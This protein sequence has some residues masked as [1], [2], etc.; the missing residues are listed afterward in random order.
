[1]YQHRS[2][3]QQNNRDKLPSIEDMLINLKVSKENDINILLLGETG[4]GKSTFINAFFNYIS[5]SSLWQAKNGYFQVVIPSQFTITDEDFQERV[6]KVGKDHNESIEIGASA[7]QSCRSYVYPV[8]GTDLKIRLIDTPG[9]GDTRGIEQ[10]NINFEN[11]LSFIGELKYLNAICILLK[12]NNS[13]LTVMFEF[14][15]KQL[16]SRLEKSASENLI[17]VFT[18]TRGTFYR[19]GETLPSLKKLLTTIKGVDIHCEKKNIFCTD[20]ESFR[21]L[22]ALKDN[23][24]FSSTDVN[25]FSQSWTQ[26]Y[27]ECLR[28]IK[29]IL[30]D[31]NNVGLIPHDVKNSISVNE[32]RRLIVQLSQPLAEI[33]ELIQ[34]N[35]RAAD[36]HREKLKHTDTSLVKLRSQ[37]YI[38]VI[39]LKVV[40]LNQPTT[41]CTSSKCSEIY[42]IGGKKK[43]HYHQTCHCP[44]YLNNVTKE[45]IGSPELI[46]CAA[47]NENGE[48]VQCSCRYQLHMHIYYLTE[49]YEAK[50]EDMLVKTQIVSKE[51]ALQIAQNVASELSSRL[52]KL[53]K[54]RDTI[55][56][57]T[58]KFACFLKMNAIAPYNDAYEAYLE[59]LIDREKSMGDVTDF[60]LIKQIEK[61]LREYSQEKH[62]IMNA[63]SQAQEGNLRI[64]ADEIITSIRCLYS[65]ELYGNKIKELVEAQNRARKDEN[66][67]QKK[68][69][70]FG[71]RHNFRG[72]G[73]AFGSR[74]RNPRS[75]NYRTNQ[76]SNQNP[77]PAPQY[78]PNFVL[79]QGNSGMTV[80]PSHSRA[81]AANPNSQHPGSI[82][83][84]LR[85]YSPNVPFTPPSLLET[86]YQPPRYYHVINTERRFRQRTRG[87]RRPRNIKPGS[88]SEPQE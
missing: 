37:L 61:M 72:R 39:N 9:I 41:V 29:Y 65:L 22:A 58:A 74:Q 68:E 17:F 49:T 7:T 60:D 45:I 71:H 16:L 69:F 48:C 78:P 75:Q 12:P 31:D 3:Q 4:V 36:I 52:M 87:D 13:R 27:E 66:K 14:C 10:D 50:S 34:D 44:C 2:G 43:W 47:M 30:G 6:I 76:S 86:N 70:V 62:A 19:P 84:P 73:R 28:M 55:T 42:E 46:N 32:A 85:P 83:F 80:Y 56:K 51:Q 40:K 82:N 59:Y 23:V 63:I 15:I 79:N 88:H 21:F 24:H 11:V 64:T 35:I 8:K 1:M 18:N 38:P 5:F 54:E 77:E 53:K 25:N 81:D 57:T 20:N 26:S 33:A 67:S